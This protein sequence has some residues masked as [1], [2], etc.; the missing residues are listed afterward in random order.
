M[1]EKVEESTEMVVTP[2]VVEDPNPLPIAHRSLGM[3]TLAPFVYEFS[4]HGQKVIGIDSDGIKFIAGVLG[5][6]VVDLDIEEKSDRLIGRATAQDQNGRSYISYVSQMKNLPN[7]KPDRFC[8]EKCSTRA[9][10]NAT[11]SLIPKPL[12]NEAIAHS[13]GESGTFMD[14]PLAQAKSKARQAVTS[15]KSR[16]KEVGL[17][18]DDV[19]N[20]AVELFGPVE[21]W[22]IATYNQLEKDV[23][24]FKNTE[25]IS[26]SNQIKRTILMINKPKYYP[27]K[28]YCVYHLGGDGMRYIGQT[29]RTIEERWYD[30]KYESENGSDSYFHNAIRKHGEDQFKII[31]VEANIPEEEFRRSRTPLHKALEYKEAKWV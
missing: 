8:W 7:G 6:S 11:A 24:Y 27:G 1:N 3:D 20:R 9:T 23:R 29:I 18:V 2:T 31:I 30:H 28:I 26:R 10:R 17:T 12:I 4:N 16:L 21:D 22:S 13:K 14:S 25:W 19:F 15:A 5:I